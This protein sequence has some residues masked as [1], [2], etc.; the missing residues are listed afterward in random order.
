M[1]ARHALERVEQ[2]G[3]WVAIPRERAPREERGQPYAPA[4][5]TEGHRGE[6]SRVAARQAIVDHN[7]RG[8]VRRLAAAVL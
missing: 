8:R 6:E 7:T 1:L 2:R 3:V 5:V 4:H